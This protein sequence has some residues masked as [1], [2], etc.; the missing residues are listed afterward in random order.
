MENRTP[1]E[2]ARVV[3][4]TGGSQGIGACIA[5]AFARDGAK[6][7]VLASSR[8]E[9]AEV[10]A[11]EIRAAGGTAAAYAADVR[12]EAALTRVAEAVERDLGPIAVLVNSAGVFFPTPVGGTDAD[13]R[14]R[15]IDINLKGTWNA[16]NVVA[17]LMRARGHGKIIN[18]SSVCATMGFAGYAIYCASKAAVSMLTRTLALELAP[19]G[20]NVNAVAPGNTRTDMNLDIRTSPQMKPM[21]DA[22]VARTPTSRVYSEPEDMAAITLFLASPGAAAI[23]GTT[24]LADEGFSIGF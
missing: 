15:T 12:D 6:V 13:A 19:H 2:N 22:I 24:I 9:K 10:V 3:L 5:H 16:I 7:A 8:I 20:I 4:V 11:A 18:F 17:P 14:D 21:L 1:E 23:H